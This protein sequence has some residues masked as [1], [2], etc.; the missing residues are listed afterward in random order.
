MAQ[1]IASVL[2]VSCG[3]ASRVLAVGSG[4]LDPT[5]A[6]QGVWHPN[7][8][9][10]LRGATAVAIQTDGR[11]VIAGTVCDSTGSSCAFMAGR[12]QSDG[13]PDPSFGSAGFAATPMLGRD[14]ANAITVQ[15]DGKIVAA[16]EA[17]ASYNDCRFALARYLTDGSLDTTFGTSGV[18]V[19][20]EFG[21]VD[22]HANALV[23][24]RGGNL[25]VAGGGFHVFMVARYTPD[26]VLDATFGIGGMVTTDFPGF[27][28][29]RGL[30]RQ[31]DGRLVV[32]RYLAD[33][34][35]DSS[36]GTGGTTSFGDSVGGGRALLLQPDGRVVVAGRGRV[37][38]IAGGSSMGSLFEGPLTV[39]RLES[40][41]TLD[42]TFG[43]GGM[44]LTDLGE[45]IATG[46]T[47]AYQSDGAIVVA[48]DISASTSDNTGFFVRYHP[49]G[50]LD[51]TLGTSRVIGRF[52]SWPDAINGLAQQVDG[53]LV[54][55]G[56]RTPGG[57]TMMLVRMETACDGPDGDGDG[58][59]DACD[60]CTAT[61]ALVRPKLVLRRINTPEYDDT[62]SLRADISLP[63]ATPVDPRTTGLRVLLEDTSGS[64]VAD[65]VFPAGTGG[66]HISGWIANTKASSFDY[67]HITPS[68]AYFGFQKVTLKRLA[69]GGARLRATG[70]HGH[71]DVPSS[72]L[73]LRLVVVL[74]ELRSPDGIC[75]DTLFA[76]PSAVCIFTGNGGGL[77]C[78]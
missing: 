26:G 11:S 78:N 32:A 64:T 69:T 55:V 5:F 17:C 57:D 20:Q 21:A 75:G 74:N 19:N 3:L 25:V 7:E 46:Q 72:A 49:D 44:V 13:F 10:I 37:A 58:I 18:V 24:D 71:Y 76:S 48:G 22:A 33:G 68:L 62:V 50:S 73:P 16:G 27:G 30:V 40:N 8:L 12:F 52:G 59:P 35:L 61:A 29:A 9:G 6:Y 15:D 41:G 54:A 67:K 28:Q 2:V 39:F 43:T 14:A 56:P 42:T 77:R 65:A 36:F 66:I 45:G 51:P 23:V 63:P 34:T 31:P 47:M 60:P 4:D 53:K 38:F 70:Y 1:R